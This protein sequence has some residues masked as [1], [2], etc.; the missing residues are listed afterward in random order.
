MSKDFLDND[1]DYWKISEVIKDLYMSDGSM[2]ILLDFERVLDE[3]DIYAFKNWELGE[4]VSGPVINRYTITCVF[5]WLG[6]NS[7][8]PK[9]AKPLLPFDSIVK[10]KKSTL[11]IP[12]KVKEPD[13]FAPG[14][15]R[16]RIVEKDIWLVEITMLKNLISDIK[17]SSTELEGQDINLDELNQ[18]YEQDL[19]KEDIKAEDEQVP[20]F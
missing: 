10:Y 19:D 11:K 18:A 15:K 12:T 2:N 9:G 17:T 8:D 13:D 7:P 16:P 5:M 6:E 20:A 14:T 1:I 3:I 4:L